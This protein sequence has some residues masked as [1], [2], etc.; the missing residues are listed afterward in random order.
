MELSLKGLIIFSCCLIVC[1]AC[2][3]SSRSLPGYIEGEYTYIASSESGTLFELYVRRGQ[4]VTKNQLL[5]ELDPEP[6]TSTVKITKAKIAE[7][8]AQVDFAKIQLSRHKTLHLKNVASKEDLDKAL[9]KYQSKLQQL[10]A[11]QAELIKSEWSLKQKVRHAPIDGRIFDI[12]YR[13]GEKV[14]SHRPVMAILAPENIKVLFYLPE[15]LLH[16]V[17]PKQQVTFTCDH[18]DKKTDA[19]ISYISPEAEF[20]PPVIYSKDTRHK[21][22]YLIRADMPKE[23]AQQFHPGQPIE[24]F[25]N[26]K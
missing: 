11:N 25:L 21:L 2:S 22:V 26:E 13:I 12:F 7:L 19:T 9:T 10:A 14:P 17:K 1:T 24:V 15:K 6:E 16:A 3:D 4:S 18:C 8:E 20:T 5:Y 23:V